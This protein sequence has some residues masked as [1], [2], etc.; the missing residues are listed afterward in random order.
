M[1]QSDRPFCKTPDFFA[2]HLADGGVRIGMYNKVAVSFPAAHQLY[3]RV[4]AVNTDTIEDLFDHLIEMGFIG[5]KYL[6]G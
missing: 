3:A 1:S 6:K 4:A 2:M 5:P